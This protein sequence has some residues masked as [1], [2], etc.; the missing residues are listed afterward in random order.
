MDAK[1]RADAYVERG[2]YLPGERP[3]RV[4]EDI[5]TALSFIVWHEPDHMQG[6][7]RAD[8][9][10]LAICRVLNVEAAEMRKIVRG[11]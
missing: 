6:G 10:F 1:R 2:G 11:E 5:L 9:A 7:Y 3:V 4:A 8:D